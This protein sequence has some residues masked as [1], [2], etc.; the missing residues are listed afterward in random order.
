[1]IFQWSLSGRRSPQVSGRRYGKKSSLFLSEYMS[2]HPSLIHLR[3]INPSENKVWEI[4]I[5]I[6]K[7]VRSFVLWSSELCLIM[8]IT[9]WCS[10]Y[11]KGS[12]RSPSTMVANFTL[13]YGYVTHESEGDICSNRCTRYSHQRIGTGTGGLGKKR[14]GR[15]ITAL[16]RLARILRRVLETWRDLLLL[17]F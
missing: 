8:F 5:F 16:L 7:C 14:T 9:A 6:N 13:L 15:E 12:L 3:N 2:L 1:M 4:Y 17:R 10:S 11:R